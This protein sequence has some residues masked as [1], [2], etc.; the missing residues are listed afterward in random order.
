MRL[1][2]VV[3]LLLWLKR[4]R[5]EL[6]ALADGSTLVLVV[7]LIVPAERALA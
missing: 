5:R 2:F 1:F 7:G 6:R 4:Y 3:P